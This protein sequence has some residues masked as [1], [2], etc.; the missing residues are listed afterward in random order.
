MATDRSSSDDQRIPDPPDLTRERQVYAC[1]Q[2]GMTFLSWSG[3]AKHMKEERAARK[4]AQSAV[5]TF[6]KVADEGRC[7]KCG[8]TQFKARRSTGGRVKT[9]VYGAVFLPLAA[10]PKQTQVQCVTCGT[11]FTRG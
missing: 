11:K 1:P 7:P 2:C 3:R 8:G 9:V 4:A 5:K 6:S 10:I